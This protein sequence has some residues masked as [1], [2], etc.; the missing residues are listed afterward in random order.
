M[1]GILINRKVVV[2][3][4]KFL[5]DMI[6]FAGVLG[7]W[8][9]SLVIVG[10][11]FNRLNVFEQ[12]AVIMHELGHRFF[13]H[14]WERMLW[15]LNPVVLFQSEEFSRRLKRQ[16]IEADN[17]AAERGYGRVLY[18][19]FEKLDWEESFSHPDKQTR[20][21]NLRKYL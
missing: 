2:A 1:F 8:K 20:L 9:W 4:V 5:S 14:F 15:I 3:Q 7:F 13:H 17:Y 12:Q 11:D 10:R 19:L 6:P 18:A 21:D 16:E